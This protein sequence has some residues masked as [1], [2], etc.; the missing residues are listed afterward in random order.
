MH[1][2]QRYRFPAFFLVCVR[3]LTRGEEEMNVK[4]SPRLSSLKPERPR[5]LRPCR[6]LNDVHA[7]A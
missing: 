1:E 6:E 4:K 7:N 2:I 5:R 3:H